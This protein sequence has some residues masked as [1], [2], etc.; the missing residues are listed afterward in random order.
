VFLFGVVVSLSRAPVAE[1]TQESALAH[2]AAR[3]VAEILLGQ[4]EK[5]GAREVAALGGEATIREVLERVAKEGGKAGVQSIVRLSKAYGVDA[6]RAARVAP[7]LTS[8][9]MERISPELVPGALRAIGRSEERA[10]IKRLDA[11]LVPSA[12]EAAARHPG[13]GAQIVDKLGAAGV[14]ASERLDTEALIRLARSA[15]AGKVAAL[16]LREQKGLIAAIVEFMEKHPHIVLTTAAVA[17]FVRYEDEILGGQGEIVP[18]PDGKPVYVSKKGMIE[19]LASESLGWLM[20]AVAAAIGL[21]G[22]SRVYWVWKRARSAHEAD[23]RALRSG[24]A[25][26]N[27]DNARHWQGS[28]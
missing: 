13:V 3:E 18:G 10:I 27:E 2:A 22:T 12:L 26:I 16:P 11:E 20:P 28:S 6:I 25:G 19:R 24:S 8:S 1:A 5:Q 17:A 21:W 23:A 4:A 14:R 9:Y 15:E 7:R